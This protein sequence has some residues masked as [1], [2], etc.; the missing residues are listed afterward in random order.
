MKKTINIPSFRNEP[1]LDFSCLEVTQNILSEVRYIRKDIL[2]NT[3]FPLIAGMPV[4]VDSVSV[5]ENPS[6]T[7]ETIG[8]IHLAS[9][10]NADDVIKLIQHSEEAK[11]WNQLSMSERAR[12]VRPIAECLRKKKNF[13]IALVMLETG[14]NAVEAD[15]EICEA[16]DFIEYYSAWGTFI[17]KLNEASIISFPGEKNEGKYVPLGAYPICISIQPWNFPIAIS[18]GPTV[19]ALIAGYSVIYKPARTSSILGSYIAR[20][21]HAAGI[22]KDVFHFFPCKGGEVADYLIRHE[23][24]NAIAFTGSKEVKSS[25]QKI[26]SEFNQKTVFSLPASDRYEKKAV[27]LESGGKNAIIVDS[28]ADMDA[29]VVGVSDSAFGFQGQKCSACSRV[30]V[31]DKNGREG[32]VYQGFLERLK[33]RV[34]SFRVGPPED[35]KNKIGPVIDENARNKIFE[36]IDLAKKNCTSQIAYEGDL[37]NVSGGYY[38]PPVIVEEFDHHSRISQEEIFGPVLVVLCARDFD[39]AVHIAN[40]T[41][42]ALT[43]GLYSRNPEHI[44]R[45]KRELRVGNIYINKKITGAIVG[46][47]PF[48]GF[49]QSGGGTKAGGWD[50]LLSLIFSVS[51]SEDTM[52]HGI[53]IEK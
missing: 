17:D 25:I 40:S 12:M 44:A 42:F 24:V 23:H 50:Y 39:E 47:Q 35:F 4:S 14:K 30:I 29:A 11:K 37:V 20:A 22:P 21:F 5:R 2:G 31:I 45:I 38:V 32:A 36:Y 7:S 28:D 16:I 13:L 48:G 10:K 49:K 26:V 27:A 19:A 43:G 6:N 34:R 53:P 15:A 51:I 3:F 18:V 41:E 8:R 46:R 1:F 52:R 33:Q 9:K